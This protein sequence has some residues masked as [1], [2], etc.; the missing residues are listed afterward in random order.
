MVGF[1]AEPD[2]RQERSRLSIAL[3]D[4]EIHNQ[5]IKNRDRNTDNKVGNPSRIKHPIM[6]YFYRCL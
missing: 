4:P 6:K 1:V 5:E 3:K 2:S